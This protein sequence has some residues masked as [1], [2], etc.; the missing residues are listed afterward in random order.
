MLI[1]QWN[2]PPLEVV[3]P[4]RERYGEGALSL[5][6]VSYWIRGVKLAQTDLAE[7]VRPG[8]P[9]D[10]NLA[11][12][13]QADRESSSFISPKASILHGHCCVHS[14]SIFDGCP[15]DEIPSLMMDARHIDIITDSRTR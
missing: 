5:S 8:R 13:R 6:Q 7:I 2:T 1:G 15:G 3:Q 4:L 10:E 11:L 9:P 14:E 12:V